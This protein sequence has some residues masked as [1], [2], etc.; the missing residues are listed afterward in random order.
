MFGSYLAAPCKNCVNRSR[1]CSDRCEKYA[2]YKRRLY[3]INT[4]RKKARA[5]INDGLKYGGGE[6]WKKRK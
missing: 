3:E 6:K 2:D 1:A 4:E 5:R